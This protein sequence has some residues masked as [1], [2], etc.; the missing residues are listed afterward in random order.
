MINRKSQKNVLSLHKLGVAS[1]KHVNLL[2]IRFA[3]S[4]QML[5]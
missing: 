3:P 2:C 5:K 1:P 4:L